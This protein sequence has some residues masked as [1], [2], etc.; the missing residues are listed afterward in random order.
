MSQEEAGV[1]D[2]GELRHLK[3]IMYKEELEREEKSIL[4]G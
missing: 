2:L 4:E 1:P 3:A